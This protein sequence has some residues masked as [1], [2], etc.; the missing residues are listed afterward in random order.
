VDVMV[1]NEET[2]Y[3]MD[4]KNKTRVWK[5]F[6]IGNQIC[7]EHG[8]LNG[9]MVREKEIVY[10]GKQLRS[11]EQQVAHRIRSRVNKMLDKGYSRNINEATGKPTNALGLLKPMLAQPLDKVKN[12]DWASCYAQYKYD[13]NRCLVTNQGGDIIAYSRN[14]KL[15]HSIDH[16]LE[17]IHI[18]E[19]W[20]I[21]GELYRHGEMLQDLAS[22]IKKDQ[23][24]SSKLHYVIYDIVSEFPYEQ[25]FILLKSIN[26][27]LSGRTD[28]AYVAPTKQVYDKQEAIEHMNQARQLG[29][30]GAILRHGMAGYED[31]KRSKSLIKI[32]EMRDDEFVITN[33]E[34]AREGWAILVCLTHQGKEFSVSAPGT[35]DMKH[36]IAKHRDTYINKY[37]R[38]EFAYYTKDGIPF[39]P[40]ATNFVD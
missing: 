22:M 16:I 31:G 35:L 21:D 6:S 27:D 39:H 20:T 2:L 29:Y 19:G 8:I 37:V 18:P 33:I 5:I 10:E 4:N 1:E 17:H 38:V 11:V 15:I 25:R 13:G 30:E 12:I 32:K 9:T 14:G 24:A 3:I 7:I 36:H 28:K 40:I 34:Q 26:D 23:D